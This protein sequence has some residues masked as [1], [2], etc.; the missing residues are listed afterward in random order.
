MLRYCYAGQSTLTRSLIGQ[1][2]M[3]I[4]LS[5]TSTTDHHTECESSRVSQ[6]SLTIQ[7]V[8]I[9]VIGMTSTWAASKINN[10]HWFIVASDVNG[11]GEL[12]SLCDMGDFS[13]SSTI[14]CYILVH[15]T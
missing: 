11:G 3:Q 14:M 1:E 7:N 4:L 13:P 5:S 2:Q 12:A 15:L 9:E 6:S 8:K 10:K